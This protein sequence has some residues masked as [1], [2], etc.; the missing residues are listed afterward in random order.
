MNAQINTDDHDAAITYASDET[1]LYIYREEDVWVSTLDEGVWSLPIR[2][3]GRINT[4]KGYEPSVFIT[5]DQQQMFVVSELGSGYG[6]RDI[7]RTQ[8]DLMAIGRL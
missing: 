3:E 6:G 8:K 1:Q 2:D 4:A 5:E 7:Y